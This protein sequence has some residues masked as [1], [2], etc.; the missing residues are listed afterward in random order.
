MP[1]FIAAACA[2]SLYTLSYLVT[3]KRAML[4]RD[5]SLAGQVCAQ[6]PCF[7][8]C[9]RIPAADPRFRHDAAFGTH[10][11]RPSGAVCSC[12]HTRASWRQRLALSV[13]GRRK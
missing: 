3:A 13:G 12:R 2:L 7:T 8:C 10:N 5:P 11:A 6:Q 4:A 9:T 1:A